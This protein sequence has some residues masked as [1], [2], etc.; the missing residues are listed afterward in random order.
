MPKLAIN[1]GKPVRSKMFPVHNFIGQEEK[2]AAI[3]VLDSGVMS[4]FLGGWDP[5]YFYGGEKVR[6]FERIW[7]DFVGAKHAVSVNSNTSG[8]V[9]AVGAANVGP[10]DE[11]IVT[12]YSMSATATAIIAYNG[13]PVFA[14]ILDDIFCLDPV[15]VRKKITS[16]TKAIMVT[17]LFGHPADIDELMN[18]AEE[19]NLIV[20]E[21]A[22]QA[23]GAIYK[24]K[25]VGALSHMTVFSL[26]CHKHIQTG[27]GGVITTNDD[28]LAEKLQLIRN[29]GESVV[30]GKGVSDLV[31]TFGFNFRYTE[32]QAAIAME[33]LKKLPWLLDCR[34]RN[35]DYLSSKLKDLPGII[36]PVVR[37]DCRHVYYVQPFIYDN[38]E[39][40]VKRDKFIDAVS[41]ELPTSPDR[42][43]VPLIWSGFVKPLYLL[44]MY[45]KLI[46]YNNDTLFGLPYYSGEVDYAA[47]LCPVAERIEN[48][49]IVM[50][51]FIRPPAEIED[52]KDVVDAFEKVYENRDELK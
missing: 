22:A 34:I 45:Q 44:P 47:G 11:V 23:P 12:P 24:N 2:K 46:A 25:F 37:K 7:S 28:R 17:D 30:E 43:N 26:N 49:K 18:I 33:Q 3:E 4:E 39:V 51:D 19:H 9:A 5:I 29:H 16:R 36:T 38:D 40:E 13:V 14:D 15:E 6:E 8:L 50:N 52:M 20:I 35:A 32:L 42:A 48:D 41:A 10:G 21:D 1:G 27:E 31:N